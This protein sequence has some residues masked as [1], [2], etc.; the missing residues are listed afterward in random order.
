ME[1]EIKEVVYEPLIKDIN[2]GKYT[3]T[4]LKDKNT[5][6]IMTVRI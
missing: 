5:Y 3:G 1:K 2:L 6:K 4:N